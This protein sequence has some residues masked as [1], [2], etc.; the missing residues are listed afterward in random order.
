MTPFLNADWVLCCPQASSILAQIDELAALISDRSHA[1]LLSDWPQMISARVLLAD[2]RDAASE[3]SR[4]DAMRE[5]E[6]AL[7]SSMSLRCCRSEAPRAVYN[8]YMAD[9]YL[10]G[11]SASA[12]TDTCAFP[13][14]ALVR[15]KGT[16]R[17]AL[18]NALPG[19]TVGR[20][21]RVDRIRDDERAEESCACADRDDI[22]LKDLIGLTRTRI[23]WPG[24]THWDYWAITVRTVP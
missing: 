4:S 12:K 21:E 14:G 3:A 7:S 24:I 20:V 11:R 2:A 8:I 13:V 6:H 15:M 22:I 5:L 17:R 10:S 16:T 23:R 1:A 18:P 9:Q 19:P